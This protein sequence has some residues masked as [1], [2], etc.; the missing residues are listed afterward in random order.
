MAGLLTR[1]RK[2][3]GFQQLLV[4][5]E[6]CDPVKQRSLMHLIGTEDPGW[7]HLVK[8]KALTFER[9]LSW[10]VEI[11]QEITTDLPV[12]ILATAYQMAGHISKTEEDLQ[13]KWLQSLPVMKAREVQE[14]SRLATF[15][16]SEQT[17]AAIRVLQMVREVEGKGRI[18]FSTFDPLLEIDKQIAA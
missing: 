6:T 10:P 4:L 17:A 8:L 16:S 3:G 11:L 1:F 18:R 12:Q 9:V 7:A 14:L 13:A 15:S 5:I 2:P